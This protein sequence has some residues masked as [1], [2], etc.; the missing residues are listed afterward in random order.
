MKIVSGIRPSGEL[1]I[2]N[3]L[4]AIKQFLEFQKIK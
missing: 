2:A 3:Y 4:G 1:T